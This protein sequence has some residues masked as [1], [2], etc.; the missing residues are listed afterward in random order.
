M[1]RPPCRCRQATVRR[2]GGRSV[3]RS[4]SRR[5][6]GDD[7][8]AIDRGGRTE[9]LGAVFRGGAAT[10]PG[11]RRAL[12]RAATQ[13][14][15]GD[16]LQALV[17]KYGTVVLAP[18]TYRLA[19]PLVLNRPVTI[20]SD[21]G[22]TLLFD[23]AAT[24]P[25]WS[26]AIKVH[27]G[28]TTLNGFAV[29]F[30]GPVRWN[31]EISWGPAVIGMTDNLDPHYD[32]HKEN[33]AFTHLDLEI[34]PVAEQVRLGRCPASDEADPGQERR[35]RRQYLAGRADR[36]LR[37][38]LAN[39]RQRLPRY[40]SRDILARSL[41]GARHPRRDR[42]RQPGSRPRSQ[43]QDVAV[44]GSHLARV[45]RYRRAQ[46]RRGAGVARRGHD[47]LEQR[48]RDHVDR[49]ISCEI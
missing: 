15:P 43:R 1:S 2:Q 18:G 27:C 8:S 42:A 16:D 26:A 29:R 36:V 31:N 19:R 22:A 17:E 24:E 44:P 39:R 12:S 45:L 23:Q 28:N 30:A 34:P 48:T 20:T 4:L 9:F 33:L 10:W 41:H 25:P 32:E 3:L 14:K 37:G 13:A 11:R 47:S 6:Q 46:Y 35:D 40:G 5:E 21:G 49:G 38:A 7:D